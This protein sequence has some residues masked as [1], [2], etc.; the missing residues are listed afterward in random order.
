MAFDANEYIR[1][2]KKTK[3]DTVSFIVHKGKREVINAAAAKRG[4]SLPKYIM[5]LVERDLTEQAESDNM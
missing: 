3:Y 4:M 5:F 1:Q 2:Y